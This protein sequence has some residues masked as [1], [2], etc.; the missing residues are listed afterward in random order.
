MVGRRILS[1]ERLPSTMDQA[2]HEARCGTIDGTVVQAKAQTAGRGR[3]QRSWVSPPGNLLLSVV[4]Y[5]SHEGLPY[6]SIIS[7]LAVARAIESETGLRPSIKWP[8]DVLIRGK[9]V[10]GLLVENALEGQAVRY[11]IVGIGLNISLDPSSLTGIADVATSLNVETGRE[12][13]AAQVLRRLLHELD[14]LYVALG[15]GH[16]S[17]EEWRQYLETLGKRVEVRWKDEVVVGYAQGVDAMGHL[18][19]RGDDGTLLT[20]PAGEVT[21]HPSAEN[22]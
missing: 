13:D 2:A 5:P 10:C 22:P 15:E 18:V 17:L 3:F 14:E 12:V 4:F 9:K 20:L 16:S 6:L 8:N 11:A 1:Y 21:L 19:L 7:S